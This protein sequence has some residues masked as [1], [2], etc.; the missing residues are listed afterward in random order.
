MRAIK[1][2]TVAAS[3]GQAVTCIFGAW[4]KV[5]TLGY[6]IT[7]ASAIVVG[8]AGSGALTKVV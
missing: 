7:R 8:A 1:D 5:I 4:I 6:N 3:T 2:L